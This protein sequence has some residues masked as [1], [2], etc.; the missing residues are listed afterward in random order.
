MNL[1]IFSTHAQVN[2]VKDQQDAI[3]GKLH[4]EYLAIEEDILSLGVE[5]PRS[6]TIRVA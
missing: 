3:N 6:H 1:K 2:F 4:T 5:V